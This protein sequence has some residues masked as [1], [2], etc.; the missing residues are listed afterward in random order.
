MKPTIISKFFPE[1]KKEEIEE[2]EKD[3]KEI[4]NNSR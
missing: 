2:L 3:I 1:I 4:A